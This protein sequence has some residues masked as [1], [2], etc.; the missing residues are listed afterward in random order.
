MT[1]ATC[2]FDFFE[3][4]LKI[5]PGRGCGEVTTTFFRRDHRTGN[6]CGTSAPELRTGLRDDDARWRLAHDVYARFERVRGTNSDVRPLAD[7]F[8]TM[9]R[10]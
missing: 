4:Q 1:L 10:I 8:T 3:G 5:E 6:L 9:A 7:A 2:T